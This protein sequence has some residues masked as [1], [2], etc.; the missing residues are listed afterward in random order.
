MRPTFHHLLDLGRLDTNFNLERIQAVSRN[1]QVYVRADKARK[2][3][4]GGP[5]QVVFVRGVLHVPGLVSV[6]GA[7]RALV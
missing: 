1:A 7:N 2:P 6:P 4:R 5:P 3:V